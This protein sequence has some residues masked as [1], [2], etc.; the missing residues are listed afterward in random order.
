MRWTCDLNYQ[1]VLIFKTPEA[2]ICF[3]DGEMWFMPIDQSFFP[4]TE[5]L[6]TYIDE[7]PHFTRKQLAVLGSNDDEE[8]EFEEKTDEQF[9]ETESKGSLLETKFSIDKIFH[10]QCLENYPNHFAAFIKLSKSTS[11]SEQ[12]KSSDLGNLLFRKIEI[13][14]TAKTLIITNIHS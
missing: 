4:S 5:G 7:T 9:Q 13:S 2:V 8:P 3:E 14:I 1:F 10:A 6:T 11:S 12:E